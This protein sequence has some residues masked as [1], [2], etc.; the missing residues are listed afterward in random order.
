MSSKKL[1]CLQHWDYWARAAPSASIIS[2]NDAAAACTG[3]DRDQ[4]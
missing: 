1:D 4:H 3:R 2:D